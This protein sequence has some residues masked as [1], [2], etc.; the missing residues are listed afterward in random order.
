MAASVKVYKLKTSL[1]SW[2]PLLVVSSTTTQVIFN[3]CLK[4]SAAILKG[5]L[6]HTAIF[7]LFREIL[8][9]RTSMVEKLSFWLRRRAVEFL[10]LRLLLVPLC[11]VIGSLGVIRIRSSVAQNFTLK[12]RGGEI[13]QKTQNLILIES[14]HKS[15]HKNGT[16]T[17][18][19]KGERHEFCAKL[20]YIKQK[21]HTWWVY[22]QTKQAV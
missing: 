2:H 17:A 9:I 14:S 1:K 11:E 8:V 20:F 21:R 7:W 5:Y 18:L 15:G 19:N 10:L 6:F 3:F 4:M 12:K 16:F 13:S 22:R